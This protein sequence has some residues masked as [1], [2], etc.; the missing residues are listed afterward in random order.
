MT[1]DPEVI[2][3]GRMPH[4][5]LDSLYLDRDDV[6]ESVKWQVNRG[7]V[8]KIL[9]TGAVFQWLNPAPYPR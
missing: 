5:A 4:N 8:D 7:T 6:D 9:A 1:A 3:I 2:N